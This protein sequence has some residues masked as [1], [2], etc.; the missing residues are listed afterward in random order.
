MGITLTANTSSAEAPDI[1]AGVYDARFDGVSAD[2]LKESQF[3]PE[4][5]RWDF[6]LMEDDKVIY[7]DG[8][9]IELQKLTSRS[10]NIK[11]K[12]TPGA[13]KVLK[14]LMTGEEFA[15]FEAGEGIDAEGLVGR[16]CQVQVIIKDNG[17]PAIDTVLPAKRS[18]KIRPRAQAEE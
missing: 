2:V 18:G 9:P 8:D 12:T 14:A 16:P 13:V 3:D 6:T 15:R 10:T 5:F 4:V 11:S 1:E 17:W 7:L